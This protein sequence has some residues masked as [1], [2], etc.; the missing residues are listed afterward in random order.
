MASLSADELAWRRSH[1]VVR[2]GVFAGDHLPAE[3]WVAGHPEGLGPDYARLLASKVGLRLS[4]DPFTDWEPV[5][6]P[7]AWEMPRYDLLL[8][9]P[10]TATRRSHFQFL[11]PYLKGYLMLVARR[12]DVRIRDEADL[13]RAR[14]VVE[15]RYLETATWAV[16]R[17]PRALILYAE[18]G[19]EALRMVAD[20]E[21]DAYIG[22]TE[23][24]TQTLLHQRP[25]DDLVLLG[26]LNVPA[27]Q[28][29][30]A[31]PLRDA[32]LT[33]VL[34]KAEAEVRPAELLRLQQRWGVD[35][36]PQ[37]MSPVAGMTANDRRV[38]DNL[39]VL[40][41]GYET[42][43]P[44]YS[45]V[46]AN[47]EFDGMAA[48][49]LAAVRKVLGLRLQLVPARDLNELQ[50]MVQAGEV[51]MVAA[52]MM[53]D[54]RGD[55]L[56]FSRAYERFPEVIVARVHGPV[57][58]GPEDLRGRRVA[59]REEAGLL[60]RLS[61]VLD[62]STLVPVGSNEAGLALVADGKADAFI[63]T[64]PA[65][66]ALIRDRY[67]ARLQMVG[68]TGLDH[69]LAFGVRR[70]H[71][72]L[73][74]MVDRVLAGIGDD[75]K[76]TI[77]A[78]WLSN[79]YR[80]G[81]PW[82]W[83]LGILLAGGAIV[84][85][86]SVAHL[87]MRRQ[88]RARTAAERKLADQLQ[89]QERLLNNIP[90]PV[91]VKDTQGRYLAVNLA[92]SKRYGVDS[93]QLIGR[94]LLET[95][96]LPVEIDAIHAFEMSVFDTGE[97]LTRE[98]RTESPDSPGG[99]RYELLWIHI[100]ELG[101]GEHAGLLGTAVDITEIRVA[102]ARARAS[103]LRLAEIARTLPSAVFELRVSADG[104]RRFTYAGGDTL[105]TIGLT[106]EQM[107]ADETLAFSHV[108]VD[109]RQLL[110]SNVAA[111]A[112]AMEPMQ[113]FDVRMHSVHGL[114][115][116]R[117][118]GGPPRRGNDGSVDWSGYWIDVT[119]S[120]E[121]AQALA[122]ANAEAKAAV[123]T[124]AAFLA[125]MSHEIRTPMAGVLG[126]VELLAQTHTDREQANMLSMVQDSAR[127]LLQILDDILDFSRI[128]S[129]R[130]ELES[131]PF[132][133]RAL[134]DGVIG[135]FSARAREKGLRLYCVIDWRLAAQFTGDAV[136]IRQ[137]ITNLLSNAIKFT[138]HGHVEVQIDLVGESEDGQRL[139][140]TVVDTGIGI[141]G[142]Q[143][144][145][146]FR[147]FT[148]A[149]SSTTRR[150]GGSG[151][152]LIICQ[153]LATL[154]GGTVQLQSTPDEGTRA[155]F[156]LMLPVAA[157]LQPL[158]G[159]AGKT[160]VLCTRDAMFAR[161]LANALSS[162]GFSVA[163]VEPADW[164]TLDCDRTDLFLV[165]RRL[166]ESGQRP[167]HGRCLLLDD[168]NSH[169]G[170]AIAAQAHGVL[171][172]NPLLWRSLRDACHAV[173]EQPAP[174]EAA[175]ERSGPR[176]RQHRWARIL[177]AE[178]HPVNRAV[179]S[180]QL[181]H[182]GFDHSLATDGEQALAMLADDAFDLLITD[183]DM[184]RMDGYALTRHIRAS[185]PG[186]TRRLPIIA[187]SASALPE[188]V[189]RC[190]DAGM[191]GFLSKPM[192]LHELD[193]M[194]ARHLDPGPGVGPWDVAPPM[195]ADPMALLTETLGSA[196]DAQSLLKELLSTCREDMREFDAALAAGDTLRQ[197]RLLHRMNGALALL[198]DMPP[199]NRDGIGA[200]PLTRQRDLL[201][202]C[203]DR[204]D[205][206]LDTPDDDVAGHVAD[207][208]A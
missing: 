138:H 94:T 47:G 39:P 42:N 106:P 159:F 123:A 104:K 91:F 53:G 31:I 132:D 161:E 64:F 19:R 122:R 92:Y 194:L 80:F 58:A 79:E 176:S 74:P 175:S 10:N 35:M 76:R 203:L 81:V 28:I 134:A 153:R 48:D 30:L 131:A 59:A 142:E 85:V 187:L 110:A 107:V 43:R 172:G 140:I 12:G 29:G 9:Q 117:T 133:L 121:Q 60:A 61:I 87:G 82:G 146:L 113:Q 164:D 198:R 130:L 127:T 24:R 41:L 152:G 63:G 145:R 77:R 71:A 38:L 70:N 206:L 50:Q 135:L 188:D 163:E 189:Q 141:S 162:M 6:W 16:K 118:A 156:E 192:T 177:V 150:F 55:D 40:R 111:A 20:G 120:H 147:P 90:Y 4:F 15:R 109:D 5:S 37:A 112:E 13:D 1:P 8:G 26:A 3:T 57:I 185:E 27:V 99:E 18:D 36:L 183:C 143:F 148:Q 139:S 11:R 205:R 25:A 14:I 66:D 21:A 197:T 200:L 101:N 103:E 44:P 151:L 97:H 114:R 102:E 124:K 116:I 173:F 72:A 180:R 208:R 154:M 155:T 51:D 193:S 17:F 2:V 144:L 56:M 34:R 126:L 105:G 128:D 78:R 158:P 23:Y 68:P 178:D 96:H 166:V 49:Y 125:M 168:S 73:L 129:G 75:E 136:R 67:A 7:A 62:Q 191:D 201:L 83:V 169:A 186:A 137:I 157:T 204:L 181:G 22:H 199:A 93:R 46:N 89:F 171:H 160:A 196:D 54:F 190:N 170:D 88:V 207:G 119:D 33:R 108:Y 32:M 167:K 45:F 149:E 179:I 65:I 98:V 202:R 115:W 195:L 174:I 182:L 165:D 100:F 52:A 84:A 69:E 86:M 184:P 95:R